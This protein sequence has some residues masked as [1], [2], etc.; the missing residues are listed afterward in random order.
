M[1]VDT[2]THTQIFVMFYPTVSFANDENHIFVRL[3]FISF[4]HFQDGRRAQQHIE[5]SWK[6]LETVSD[7]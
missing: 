3:L 2:H 7:R 4:Q 1:C 5:N 6:Q